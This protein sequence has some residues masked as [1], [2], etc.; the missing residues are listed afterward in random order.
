MPH[1]RFC[2]HVHSYQHNWYDAEKRCQR[3]GGHLASI[4]DA[5]ENKFIEDLVV[6]KGE[7]SASGGIR[8]WIGL[9]LQGGASVNNSLCC[10]DF[11]R[12]RLSMIFRFQTTSIGP[13]SSGRIRLNL[14]LPTGPPASRTMQMIMKLVVKSTQTVTGMMLHV[15]RLTSWL[16]FA[17]ESVQQR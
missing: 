17:N 5:A 11:L 2:Y 4:H 9:H 12:S 10:I 15:R 14:S 6:S 3:E 16:M 1:G 8:A 13:L 7:A